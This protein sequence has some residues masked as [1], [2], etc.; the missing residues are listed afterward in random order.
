MR[1]RV[2]SW[3][4]LVLG[5]ALCGGCDSIPGTAKKTEVK[6]SYALEVEDG[7]QAKRVGEDFRFR[8]GDRFRVLLRSR[9]ATHV[10]LFHRG[11]GEE[12]HTVLF[13]SRGSSVI[14]PI[15]EGTDVPVPDR[16]WMEMDSE[17][18]DESLLLVAST[19]PVSSLD[20]RDSTVP[21]EELE[22]AVA[23]VE[24]Q[25]QAEATAR[26]KDG[27]WSVFTA[28]GGKELAAVVRLTLRHE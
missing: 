27:D 1:T 18:G 6:V 16:G 20:F 14:N 17:P 21:R 12:D 10:Y 9:P 25:F 3:T 2:T 28:T 7:G 4:A 23:R 11:T 13:P 15:K 22:G 24:R 5:A 26:S 8:S 19:V